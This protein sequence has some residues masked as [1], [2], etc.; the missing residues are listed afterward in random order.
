M[1]E[2]E[3]LGIAGEPDLKADQGVAIAAPMMVQ[4]NK[5]Y[6]TAARAG[7]VMKTYTYLPIPGDPYTTTVTLV[8]GWVSEI[9]RIRKF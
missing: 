4:V 5:N 6:S 1:S 7:L 3:V 8:G 9:E 2:G